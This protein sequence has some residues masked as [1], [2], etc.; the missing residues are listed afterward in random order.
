VVA[1]RAPANWA[2]LIADADVALLSGDPVRAFRL[3]AR[4]AA[5]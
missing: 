1:G 5:G 2:A 3:L 4:V